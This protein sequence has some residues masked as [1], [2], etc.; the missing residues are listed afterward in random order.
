MIAL[1]IPASLIVFA[2]IS[3]P[4]GVATAIV[5]TAGSLALLLG[6]AP[7]ITVDDGELRAGRARIPARLLGD[8]ALARGTEARHERG[9]G[10]DARAHLLLRGWVDPVARVAVVDPADPTPYWLL[11]TRHPD[12]LA[13]A[14]EAA[15]RAQTGSA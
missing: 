4:A 12:E 3:L 5:L 10:L 2:P 8:V 9:P 13:A 15:K 7:T 11:S 1:V 14:I 6:S